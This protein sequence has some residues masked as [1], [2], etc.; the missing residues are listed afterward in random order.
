MAK[1]GGCTEGA[2]AT[3]WECSTTDI[4]K[5]GGGEEADERGAREAICAA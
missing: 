5:K 1:Y 3:N 4:E 2:M